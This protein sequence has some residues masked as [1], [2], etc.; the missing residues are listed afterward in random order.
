MENPQQHRTQ[1]LSHDGCNN[2]SCQVQEHNKG[3]EYLSVCFAST[4]VGLSNLTEPQSAPQHMISSWRMHKG[5]HSTD[6]GGFAATAGIAL[7]Q[8]EIT[9]PLAGYTLADGSSKH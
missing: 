5:H 4:L 8:W 7:K 1:A 3:P 2:T 6:G 9:K